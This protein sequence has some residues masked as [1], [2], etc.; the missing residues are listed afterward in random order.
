MRC[1]DEPLRFAL[2]RLHPGE[3][4]V[5]I[6]WRGNERFPVTTAGARLEVPP[7]RR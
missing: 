3:Y 4:D 5:Q 6:E 1:G 2:P 7:R